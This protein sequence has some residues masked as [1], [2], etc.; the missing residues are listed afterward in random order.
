LRSSSDLPRKTQRKP[1]LLPRDRQ[2][3]LAS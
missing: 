3:L 2:G 1:A